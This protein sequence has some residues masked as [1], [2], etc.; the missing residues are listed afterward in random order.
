MKRKILFILLFLC[1]F[2]AVMPA[3]EDLP[4]TF[5]APDSVNEL[6]L[7]FNSSDTLGFDKKDVP[8]IFTPN[9][10]NTNDYFQV[11]V[12]AGNVY[13]LMIFT[14]TGTKVYNSTSPRI[15]WDGRNTGGNEVPEGIYYYVIKLSGKASK[16]GIC[17]C[18][19]LYR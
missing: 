7:I 13:D 1:V 4:G 11:N 5:N 2:V 9:G 6:L 3:Q 14:R 15:F 18:L 17:G 10:D 16:D 19:Y 8:N 12:P